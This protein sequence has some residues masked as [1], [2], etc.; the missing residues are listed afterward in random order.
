MSVH[1]FVCQVNGLHIGRQEGL[2][3]LYKTKFQPGFEM[4]SFAP[5]IVWLI[6]SN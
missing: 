2:S 3:Q 1:L 4:A 6:A 5:D